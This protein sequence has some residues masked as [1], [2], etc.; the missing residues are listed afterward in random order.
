MLDYR[1]GAL[2]H[3]VVVRN[4]FSEVANKKDGF[5]HLPRRLAGWQL[6]GNH[7]TASECRTHYRYC[8]NSVNNI[9]AAQ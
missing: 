1:S 4:I 5:R 7:P 6:P 9:Q 2:L 3:F 8:L